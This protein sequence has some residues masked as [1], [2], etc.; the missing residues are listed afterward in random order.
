[1]YC[2][3]AFFTRNSKEN[4]GSHKNKAFIVKDMY[5]A[6]DPLLLPRSVP[7][8]WYLGAHGGS[9][10]LLISVTGTNL[11]DKDKIMVQQGCQNKSQSGGGLVTI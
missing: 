3:Y 7:I 2:V 4:Q 11:I 6:F 10:S 8:L 9:M 5:F 1:M